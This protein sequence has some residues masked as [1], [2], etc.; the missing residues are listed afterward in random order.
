MVGDG[1][2]LT[3]F[4]TSWRQAFYLSGFVELLVSFTVE[5]AIPL[6]EGRQLTVAN[7]APEQIGE[8]WTEQQRRTRTNH[9]VKQRTRDCFVWRAAHCIS[10]YCMW[11]QVLEK[12]QSMWVGQ[13]KVNLTNAILLTHL[14]Q[15]EK[16]FVL[17]ILP[18]MLRYCVPARL[19][20]ILVELDELFLG[21]YYCACWVMT[22]STWM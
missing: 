4:W 12:R 19:V 6:D 3:T 5:L 14:L 10:S 18:W 22:L 20:S 13:E 17:I 15:S 1:F 9:E 11:T 16:L 7:S 8:H 2:C 21:C